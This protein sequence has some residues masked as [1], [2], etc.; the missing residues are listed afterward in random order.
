M[1]DEPLPSASWLT[2][3]CYKVHSPLFFWLAFVGILASGGILTFWWLVDSEV[4]VSLR[5][6][7]LLVLVASVI[8]GTLNVM[9]AFGW[10][11][12]TNGF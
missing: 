11:D 12:H 6:V 8:V 2:V 9:W 10:V 1:G 5:I 3:L 7:V 4:R